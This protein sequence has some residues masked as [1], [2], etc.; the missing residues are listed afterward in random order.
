MADTRE[1]LFGPSPQDI[2]AA[3]AQ[4]GQQDA[5]GWA[6]LPAGRGAVAAAA[7]AGQA[8]G[9]LGG[10]LMGGQDPAQA[11]AQRMQ[12]AQQE[13]EAQAQS[14]GIDLAS[15]PKDYYKVAAQTLQK[16]GLVDEAQ[17]V[18]GIAQNHDL[19]EREMKVKERPTAGQGVKMSG[20][21]MYSPDGTYQAIPEYQGKGS[22]EKDSALAVAKQD[23]EQGKITKEEYEA[24]YKK[25]T[26]IPV[27]TQI[28]NYPNAPKSFA[29]ELGTVAA[30]DQYTIAATARDAPV[31]VAKAQT[32]I[33]ALD[34]PSLIIGPGA[35][36]R[37][38]IAKGLNIA[39]ADNNESINNTQTLGS[40]LAD[41]TLSAIATSG[42]GTGQGFTEKDKQMLQDAR[43]GRLPMTKETLR[44]ISIMNIKA[45]RYAVEKW[46]NQLSNYD[47]ETKKT[48]RSVGVP[49][50]P[51]PL[52]E[53]PKPK[54]Y[55]TS[56]EID[57]K[58]PAGWE[59]EWK[60][61]TPDEKQKI[62]SKGKN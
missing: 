32:V 46:N 44:N 7:S 59:K 17:N 34:D 61:L 56:K 50:D 20:N 31:S 6:Q 54:K 43:A 42:L 16:Y 36:A 49:T 35:D 9:N 38:V 23:Y 40:Q 60:Y 24:L 57:G 30:K 2:A 1:S 33:T 8:F 41:T 37:L 27:G 4:Q 10:K 3:Q 21:I 62:L 14:M 48:L 55:P 12:A 47:E 28:N 25:L 13:T 58:I 26:N 18:M 11:K 5:M 45:Q 51:Y 52:P 39:G 53:I 22:A 19:A 15:N 29:Q